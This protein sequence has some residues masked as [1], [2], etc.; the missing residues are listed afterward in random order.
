MLNLLCEN[1]ITGIAPGAGKCGWTLPGVFSGLVRDQIASFP[2]LRPHQRH[3]WHSFL[4]QV[5]TLA[6]Q[7]AATS[8]LPDDEETWHRLMANLTP[9]WPNGEPWSLIVEDAAKPALLQPPVPGAD[10]TAFKR[11]ETPD[12]LDMLV[13]AKNHDLKA[14]RMRGAA[15]EDWLFSLL[16][17][18]TQEGVM[19]AGNYGIS[20]MNGGYGSRPGFGL[21]L[22]TGTVGRRHGN[23]IRATA[24]ALYRDLPAHKARP[25]SWS[26]H[27]PGS[28]ERLTANSRLGA[29]GKGLSLSADGFSYRKLA[30]LLHP[31]K[32]KLPILAKAGGNE[33]HE[34]LVWVARSICRGQGK[35][36]GYHERRIPLSRK[37]L[38]T[39]ATRQET[40]AEIA[41]SHV[42][43]LNE[44][45]L[46]LRAA[47]CSM[48]EGAPGKAATDKVT[49]A[50]FAE[51][52]LARLE[53][54]AEEDF[55]EDLWDEA[56]AEETERSRILFEWL[57][58]QRLRGQQLLIEAA[59]SMPQP[60]TRRYKALA[61]A[62]IAF[63]G[64]LSRST[65]FAHLSNQEKPV[66]NQGN[67]AN[68]SAP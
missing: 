7:K 30:E 62:Q 61:Q 28:R 15:P 2:S 41:E 18:Q 46:A 27:L 13:T 55:F 50:R 24:P 51:P 37:A 8:D 48:T 29:D 16:S 10:L 66:G 44:L 68:R 49:P 6:M 23:T 47:L 67:A 39:L 56:G 38:A 59:S 45:R 12:A 25:C 40:V 5:A 20:R 43:A 64:R 63:R 42:M 53:R 22:N 11:I 3:V 57:K 36:E 1:I 14:E 33:P 9:E 19:G 17:L 34:D 58:K 54:E 21:E 31:S 4:V 52:W 60:I 26:N 35:T 32:F 65:A